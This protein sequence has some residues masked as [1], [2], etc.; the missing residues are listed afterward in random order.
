MKFLS[1]FSSGVLLCFT[2]LFSSVSHA[3]LIAD[4]DTET[5][6][7]RVSTGGFAWTASYDIG[8][9][10]QNLLIDVDVFLSGDDPG[11]DLRNIW[12]QGIESIWSNTFDI[13]DGT[14]YYDTLFNVDW[15]STS[16]GA[17]H[18]VIVHTGN[19]NV[20][21]VDWYTGSPS[22]WPYSYQDEMAAHEFGHMIGLFDEY[23][24][25]ALDPVTKLIRPNSIMGQNL[26]APQIDH[27]DA[28]MSWTSAKS[29][30][31]S[32]SLVSD[33]GDHFYDLSVSV[34]E[35]STVMLFVLAG[36]GLVMRTRM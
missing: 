1:L 14:F 28:F 5:V 4:I 29:G 20:N 35:P 16:A 8:F 34:P 9:V 22:G 26:A 33:R 36:F 10:N 7:Y 12:E 15:L 27:F 31:Q 23:N 25:G 3:G 21:K 30:A 17:D 2:V 11:N 6:S 18:T 32:L 19:G 24:G 13:F